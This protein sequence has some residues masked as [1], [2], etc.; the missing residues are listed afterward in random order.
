[1]NSTVEPLI[2]TLSDQNVEVRRVAVGCLG[3]VGDRRAIEPLLA[4]LRGQ[5]LERY[6][7]RRSQ[8]FG[9]YVPG[10]GAR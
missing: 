1:M 4:A 3:K 10:G 8:S 7:Q 6:P 2:S 9:Q 5:G